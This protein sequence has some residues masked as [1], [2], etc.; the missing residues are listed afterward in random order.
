MMLPEKQSV[1]LK[2][3]FSYTIKIL[4]GVM[5]HKT[6]MDENTGF[7]YVDRENAI[8]VHSLYESV[9]RCE[10]IRRTMEYQK[11]NNKATK[12]YTQRLACRLNSS[13]SFFNA[14][15][16]RAEEMFIENGKVKIDHLFI[17]GP[18]DTHKTFIN[19]VEMNRGLCKAIN[20]LYHTHSTRV[21][22]LCNEGI[23]NHITIEK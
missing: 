9:Y 16:Q 5:L 2:V 23:L 1:D 10:R 18:D 3:A 7:I 12:T 15:I 13:L 17:C 20:R 11:E 22:V 8:V 21:D 19:S 14:I 6:K 4:G